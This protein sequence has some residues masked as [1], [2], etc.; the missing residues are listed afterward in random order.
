M[1]SLFFASTFIASTF[2]R[3]NEKLLCRLGLLHRLVV[4][5]A[6]AILLA[7]P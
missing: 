3:F 6:A 7:H 2:Y 1:T 4:T 5:A